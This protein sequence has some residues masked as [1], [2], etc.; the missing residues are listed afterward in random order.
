MNHPDPSPTQSF[1]TEL[2]TPPG[3]PLNK[4]DRLKKLKVRYMGVTEPGDNE[5]TN[6]DIMREFGVK[7]RHATEIIHKMVEDGVV[8]YVG[9]TPKGKHIYRLVV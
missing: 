8:A 2:L 6:D 5:I 7:P 3:H 9:K 4:S 1:V